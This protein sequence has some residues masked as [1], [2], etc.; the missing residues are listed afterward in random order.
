MAK[1]NN[2]LVVRLD[3]ATELLI[4]TLIHCIQRLNERVDELEKRFG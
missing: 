2:T 3:P 4:Q 1:Q